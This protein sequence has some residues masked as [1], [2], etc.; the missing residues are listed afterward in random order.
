MGRKAAPRLHPLLPGMTGA[1][2]FVQSTLDCQPRKLSLN[3]FLL[4]K[5]SS[6]A[7]LCLVWLALT[8]EEVGIGRGG[9]ILLLQELVEE[10]GEAGD[11][12]GEGA[13][14]QDHQHEKRVHEEF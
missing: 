3:V 5:S 9:T 7:C 12:G 8:D 11:D 10:C 14:S 2:Q 13:L 6:G 1:Q 4:G